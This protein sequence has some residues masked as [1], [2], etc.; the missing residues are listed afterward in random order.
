MTHLWWGA[1]FLDMNL[2]GFLSPKAPPNVAP[3]REGLV[4]VSYILLFLQ[5]LVF[6]NYRLD[7]NKIGIKLITKEVV[8]VCFNLLSKSIIKASLP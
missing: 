8:V 2:G 6:I 1:K 4:L 3:D 7:Y 5:T